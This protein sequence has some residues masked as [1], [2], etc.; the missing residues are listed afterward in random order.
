MLKVILKEWRNWNCRIYFWPL[1]PDKT[2]ETSIGEKVCLSSWNTAIVVTVHL[3]LKHC[4]SIILASQWKIR[5]FGRNSQCWNLS[6]KM[7][8]SNSVYRM[9][10]RYSWSCKEFIFWSILWLEEYCD[11]L[12]YVWGFRL[13]AGSNAAFKSHCTTGPWRLLAHSQ[14]RGSQLSWP[15]WRSNAFPD[16]V[17][18]FNLVSNFRPGERSSFWRNFRYWVTY[19]ASVKQW[20]NFVV[21]F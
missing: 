4:H 15:N 2:F 18:C 20:A 14:F 6:G 10:Y 1:T 9:H 19:P 7:A 3:Y 11:I 21:L 17:L 5:K 8:T 16:F 13:S 12:I